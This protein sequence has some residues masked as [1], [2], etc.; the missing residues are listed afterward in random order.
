MVLPVL[1]QV[2]SDC[3]KVPPANE[4]KSLFLKFQPIWYNIYTTGYSSSIHKRLKFQLSCS[5]GGGS[6]WEQHSKFHH[7]DLQGE[8]SRKG[9][10]VT[11]PWKRRWKTTNR[12][13]GSRGYFMSDSVTN[14]D[15]TPT[16]K[17]RRE[18]GYMWCVCKHLCLCRC[19][20]MQ[21]HVCLYVEHTRLSVRMCTVG[22]WT[23][24]ASTVWV[25]LYV[26]LF[27]EGQHSTVNVFS[28]WFS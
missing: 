9:R 12:I 14:T 20:C 24:G 19:A 3:R 16:T 4:W 25:H 1:L 17:Y 13:F 5:L 11:E 23:T 2:S 6:G 8:G 28:L 7:S 18:C 21:M 27:G 26:G 15:T 22:P 10:G